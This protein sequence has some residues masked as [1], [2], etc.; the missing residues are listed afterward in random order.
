MKREELT[1]REI[2]ALEYFFKKVHHTATIETY[3]PTDDEFA[4]LA[5]LVAFVEDELWREEAEIESDFGRV[6]DNPDYDENLDDDPFPS[7]YDNPYYD[8]NLD[9]DQQSIDFWN[10]Y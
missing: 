4:N 9:M 5:E 8:E 3:D 2:K 1:E 6:Y 7:V 10:E